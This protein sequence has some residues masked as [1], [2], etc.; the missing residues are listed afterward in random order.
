LNTKSPAANTQTSATSGLHDP[1]GRRFAYGRPTPDD[2]H[3]A[4]PGV[5]AGRS[6]SEGGFEPP[7]PVKVTR[8]STESR[9]LQL[10][11]SNALQHR[12]VRGRRRPGEAHGSRCTVYRA[13]GAI[14]GATGASAA[15]R[16][17]PRG[18]TPRGRAA[19]SRW[20]SRS[21]PPRA[22]PRREGSAWW[23]VGRRRAS[24]DAS[25]RAPRC[26]SGPSR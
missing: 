18:S 8:P 5:S 13:R 12:F 4:E 14:L 15:E 26:R 9:T 2:A 16:F 21:R 19:D 10:V 22:R 3:R 6:V 1:R 20:R 11:S 24:G 17:P 23:R 25:D 7:R